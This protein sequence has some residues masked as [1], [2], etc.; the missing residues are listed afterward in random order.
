MPSFSAF[1]LSDLTWSVLS[2][3]QQHQLKPRKLMG[4][5]AYG[6]AANLAYLVEEKQVAP[7]IPA[8]K[9]YREV[10]GVFSV[11]DFVWSEE[12][13][14]YTCPNNKNSRL[15]GGKASQV[16]PELPRQ[17]RLSTDLVKATVENAP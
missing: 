13:D 16:S 1:S 6:A 12:T 2:A 15:D 9:Q 17:T 8:R 7:H 3:N 11:P 14:E 4:D 5:T 10:E